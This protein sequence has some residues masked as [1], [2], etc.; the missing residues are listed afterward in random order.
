MNKRSGKYEIFLVGRY[1]CDLVFTNLPELPRLGHEVY[2]SD[3]HLIPGGVYT[4]AV[5]LHRLGVKT[6]WPC[7]F[8]SDPFS[9]FVREKAL[10]EGVDSAFFRDSG[11][12]S[13]RIS[14]SFSFK[15]ERAFLSYTDPLPEYDY[16]DLI[17][18][19]RPEWV[20][21]THLL[22][23]HQLEEIISSARE[24]GAKVFMDC[25]AH[26]YTLESTGI[27]KALHQ[28]DVFSPNA[29]E[30][31]QLT[32]KENLEDALAN[33]SELIPIVI[34]KDGRNGCLFQDGRDTMH[35]EGIEV[36][37]ADT[38]GAGDNFDCGFLFGQL[39][40][41]DLLTSLRIANICGGLSATGY[42]GASSSPTRAE[43]MRVL[44][45]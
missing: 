43:I 34:I 33:L 27:R 44:R 37:V 21:I 20:Y 18:E 3:F 14:A 24:V 40:E 22:I 41:Y 25:Q 23:G 26:T 30:A 28:V 13:L 32:G 7:L 5:A 39:R 8:G 11:S 1:F 38:T 17:L 19:T 45:S 36:D 4:P 35:V 29:E 31:Y 15:D 9:H 16:T 10:S 6:A 12:P 2:S 42:G